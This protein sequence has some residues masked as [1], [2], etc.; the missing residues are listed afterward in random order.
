MSITLLIVLITGLVSYRAFQDQSLFY[1]LAHWPVKEHGNKEYH[2]LLTHGFVHGSWAHLLI[3]M[4]VLWSFG[5]FIEYQFRF[6]FGNTI[7]PLLFV[8]VYLLTIV[9]ASLPTH[10][11]K[12]D[13]ESYLSVGASGAVSGI[14][15]IYILLDPWQSLYLLA[16]IEIPGIVF[17]V[18]YLWYSSYASKNVQDRIDH[19]AH[20]YG[21]LLGVAY[22]LLLKPSLGADFV[23]QLVDGFP[24]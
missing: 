11:N 23:R 8:I 12:K 4:F 16:L 19:E 9:T 5:E 6:F 13:K 17:G 22:M 14:V 1:R 2:R 18:L 20:F 7:G 24:L 3:N 10:F 15:F 21:A